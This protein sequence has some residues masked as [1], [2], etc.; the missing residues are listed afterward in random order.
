MHPDV[1]SALLSRTL[2]ACSVEGLD[3][4]DA[5]SPE[6]SLL[7]SGFGNVIEEI[8]HLEPASSVENLPESC[9]DERLEQA[10]QLLQSTDVQM[11][12]EA[13]KT[14]VQFRVQSAV[15]AISKVARN[16]SEPN[17]RS[18]AISTLGTINHE[19]VFPAVLIGMAD[20]AREVRASAARSLNRLSFD[21]A[22]A[23]VRVLETSDEETVTSVAR[24]CLQAGIVSQNLDRLANSDHRQAYETFSLICLLSKANLNEAVLSAISVHPNIDVRLK[25]VH[26]FSC[27]GHPATVSQLRELAVT[28]GMGEEVKTALLE[29]IYKLEQAKPT[30]A[31]SPASQDLDS[32]QELEAFNADTIG[33]HFE[34]Q[35]ESQFN[36]DQPDPVE[37][38]L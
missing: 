18:L 23:Y 2:S 9:D 36:E 37:L 25:V 1:P 4:F 29:A 7:G 11:R 10:L 6:T 38:E 30:E 19:S 26:L 35:L 5:I 3:F 20:D 13:L 16:D 15:D 33:A 27:T 34:P 22:D 21:R 24:A 8:T 12:S 28:D 14:L 31:A 17:L 32:L